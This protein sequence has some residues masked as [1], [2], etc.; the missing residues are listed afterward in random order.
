MNEHLIS[1]TFSVTFSTNFEKKTILKVYFRLIRFPLILSVLLSCAVRDYD[2]SGIKTTEKESFS[3]PVGWFSG[4][5]GDYSFATK[6]EYA[7]GIDLNDYQQI[8][9][10]DCPPRA[11][12]MLDKR[13]KIIADSMNVFYTLVDS[14]R[15]YF[16][17]DSRSTLINMKNIN[18]LSVKN[19]G[20]FT[21]EG[22]T[23][24]DDSLNCS[25]FFRLKDDFVTSWA[26]LKNNGSTRIFTLKEGKFFADKSEFEKGYLKANFSFVYKSEN[27]FRALY[28]SGKIYA[29][30]TGL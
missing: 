27:S 13:R 19:Y 4:L 16:S 8:I 6:W 20:D 23:K 5:K 28:W 1:L 12:K 17:L 10:W 22:F 30:I 24:S 26:Y 2:Y 9:C 21:L 11:Q 3:I 18:Y 25:L 14:T 29:K 15:H 7:S